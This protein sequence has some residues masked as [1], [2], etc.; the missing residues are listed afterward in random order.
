MILFVMITLFTL[1]TDH[2]MNPM[3]NF[4]VWIVF[5]IDFMVRFILSKEKWIF[6]KRNP[7]LVIAIIPFDQFFQIARI[8][9]LIYFFRLKTITKYYVQPFVDKMT[10]RTKLLMLFT[11]LWF[12][13]G[14][15][16]LLY[17]IEEHIES[18][19]HSI[20]IV[21]QQLL[22]FGQRATE[23]QSNLS[24]WL[25]VVTTIIGV[26]LHGIALQWVFVQGERWW[27][28]RKQNQK[29]DFKGF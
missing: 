24:V 17:I 5:F 13:A 21:T 15:A 9:R 23:V 29:T 11:L 8:V 26:L 4:F 20:R 25:F 10:F 27:Q 22:F 18:Y 28:Q 14:E 12:L 7:F 2:G 16:Y 1:W 6:V 3:V 19:F